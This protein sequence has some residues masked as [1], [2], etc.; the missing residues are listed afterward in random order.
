MYC[1]WNDINSIN[2][3]FVQTFEIQKLNLVLKIEV[4]FFNGFATLKKKILANSTLFMAFVEKFLF[5]RMSIRFMHLL[6]SQVATHKHRLLLSIFI[7]FM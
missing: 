7:T 6:F 1:E 3:N 4:I 5:M 2:T